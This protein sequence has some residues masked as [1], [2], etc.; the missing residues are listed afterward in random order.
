MSEIIE[1]IWQ[2]IL[3]LFGRGVRTRVE[4]HRASFLFDGAGTRVMNILSPACDD[5][6]FKAIVDRCKSNGDDTIYLYLAFERDGPWGPFS[7]YDGNQIGSIIDNGM[8]EHIRRR[9]KYCRGEGLAVV[10][11]LRADDS[12]TF[13]RV[14][15]DRQIA[16]QT[17]AVALFDRYALAWVIGLEL[18]EYMT[19]HDCQNYATH[20]ASHTDRHVGTHQKPGRFEYATLAGVD[21]C[22]YQY[23]FGKRPEQVQSETAMIAGAIGK[24]VVACEYHK[25]SDSAQ[26]K[27]LGD[28]AMAG[29]AY[30]TGNGRN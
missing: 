21:G 27:A 26:A 9:V 23:G 3:R 14:S 6:T 20:L 11:W 25:L 18:D 12:P 16:Y 29:G 13:N 22:W 7:F 4:G 10:F 30:G 2:F 8:V 28:A 15:A 24:P 19:A 5:G 17:D 1:S